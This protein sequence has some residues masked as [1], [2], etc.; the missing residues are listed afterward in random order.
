[1]ATQRPLA[2][3]RLAALQAANLSP[4]SIVAALQVGD[5]FLHALNG[6]VETPTRV[7]TGQGQLEADQ[8]MV[9]DWERQRANAWPKEYYPNG[10]RTEARTWRPDVI[11]RD[12]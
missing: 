2:D 1:M 3:A 12:S 11:R 7:V 4:V 5:E 10:F 8:R 6:S 9:E